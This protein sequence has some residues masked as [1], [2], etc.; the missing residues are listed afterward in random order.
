M[1]SNVFIKLT[2]D[3]VDRFFYLIVLAVGSLLILSAKF[4]DYN[5]L[6]V[7]LSIVL[8]LVY[9]SVCMG[10]DQFRLPVER[11]GDN[12]Y[13]L[14][15]IFTLVS[16]AYAL[17]AFNEGRGTN[18]L[19]SDFG[20][21]L[22]STICGI[23]TRV[24]IQQFR[25]DTAEVESATRESLTQTAD[26]VRAELL[27][28]VEDV[29][30]LS[31]AY[32]DKLGQLNQELTKDAVTTVEQLKADLAHHKALSTSLRQSYDKVT[33]SHRDSTDALI[34]QLSRLAP[35]VSGRKEDLERSFDAL[36]DSIRRLRLD[37]PP[38]LFDSMRAALE[39][40]SLAI[41]GFTRVVDHSDAAVRGSIDQLSQ[42]L[43]EAA[44]GVR[45]FQLVAPPELFAAIEAAI[46]NASVTID[47]FATRLLAVV[48]QYEQANFQIPE[49]AFEPLR[50]RLLAVT[51]ELCRVN[52]E[53]VT[54]ERVRLAETTTQV[55]AMLV[56]SAQTVND[57]VNA[58]S[59]QSQTLQLNGQRLDDSTTRLNVSVTS[60][61]NAV[62]N[63]TVAL[64]ETNRRIDSGAGTFS[65]FGRRN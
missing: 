5:K 33:K 56:A 1:P 11:V 22:A 58:I 27:N 59:V 24:V 21:A 34:E 64:A 8:I 37:A 55:N 57:G 63:L 13:Y 52:Q 48:A 3:S 23:G 43:V 30:I 46:R 16:L 42:A 31:I 9:A 39:Q 44:A 29:Q 6:A 12:S 41:Q 4:F 50:E 28:V 40:S 62:T 2:S 47:D 53:L 51:E 20:L 38:H 18:Q 26:A 49:T 17:W 61:T 54:N 7:L 32:R 15:F 25:L 36:I 45:Q 10:I 65:L 19:V 35:S 60:L 14:G